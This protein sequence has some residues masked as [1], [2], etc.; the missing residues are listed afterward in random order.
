MPDDPKLMVALVTSL[1]ALAGTGYTTIAS[2]IG[3][4]KIERLKAD[5]EAAREE[6]QA[7]FETSKVVSRFRDPLMHAAY[8]LQS[9]IYNIVRLDFLKTYLVNGSPREKEY[10]VENTVFLFAQFLGW[11]EAIREEIQFLDLGADGETKRLRQLQDSIYALLQSPRF[12]PSFRIFAGEQR[13][14]G[15]LMIDHSASTCRC[16]GFA[17][18]MTSHKPEL[19]RWLDPL[20]NGLAQMAAHADPPDQ[21]LVSIQHSMIDLLDFLDPQFVRFPAAT[22]GKI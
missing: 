19:D 6:R 11:T 10:A 16:M 2:Y 15:E 20:R 14:I 4:R 13:A 7:R 9:R 22:R 5:L 8:D 3:Q 21:R 1:V 17:A 12:S 18:F